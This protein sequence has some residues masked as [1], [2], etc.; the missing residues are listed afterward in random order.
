METAERCPVAGRRR[1]GDGLGVMDFESRGTTPDIGRV[2]PK[3]YNAAGWAIVVST[4]CRPHWPATQER[5]LRCRLGSNGCTTHFEKAGGVTSFLFSIGVQAQ[6]S[7]EDSSVP[8]SSS[9]PDR[10]TPRWEIGRAESFGGMQVRVMEIT[11]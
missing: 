8:T 7:R 4:P 3:T 5:R 2:L 6:I 11:V 9:A 1:Y 10:A